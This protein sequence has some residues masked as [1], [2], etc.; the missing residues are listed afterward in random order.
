MLTKSGPTFASR[1]A[2]SILTEIGCPELIVESDEAYYEEAIKYATDKQSLELIK[3]KVIK[4]KEG[5]ALFKPQLFAKNLE[6]IYSGLI[7]S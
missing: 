7:S 5:S 2:G 4:G 6:E 1:V 3:N